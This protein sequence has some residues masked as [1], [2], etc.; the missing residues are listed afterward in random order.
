M[1]QFDPPLLTHA[2]KAVLDE[3]TVDT[4]APAV[5]MQIHRDGLSVDGVFGFSDPATQQAASS[6]QPFEVG[7]QGKMMTA[8]IVLQMVAEGKID[9]DASLSDYV[10]ASYMAGIANAGEATIR[11]LLANRSGVP[12]FDTVVGESGL[13]EF[14]ERLTAN[15]GQYMGPEVFLDIVKGEPATFA[16]GE[17]YLY[18]NTNF[19]LLGHLIET[20]SGNTLADEMQ[21]RIFDP[22]G[23]QSSK[24]DPFSRDDGR[25]NSYADL[26]DGMPIDVTQIPIDYAGAGGV[27]STTSDMIRFMDALLV[28]QTLLPADMLQQMTDFRGP[29][30]TP[31]GNGFGLGLSANL[32][33][34][35]LFIGFQGGTL[36]TNTGTILH[37]Q[38]GTIISVAATH[39][40]VD[41][42]DLLLNAFLQIF[43]DEAW[44]RF[45]PDA[46]SFLIAGA[47]AEIDLKEIAGIGETE[48]TKLFLN[49]A[50]LIFEGALSEQDVDRFSFED[51]SKLWIGSQTRDRFDVFRDA[52]ETRHL[53]N[54]LIGLGGKD[55]LAG[56]HGNDKLRGGADGD[57]L[58]GRTGDDVIDGGSGRDILRGGAGEDVL[59]G[60]TG[61]DILIGGRGSDVFV[62]QNG[63]GSDRI[64]GF[65]TG[66]DRLDFSQTGLQFD[67]LTIET[68]WWGGVRVIYGIGDFATITGCLDGLDEGDFI[69]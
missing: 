50:S 24:L 27:V 55:I 66:A 63:D 11:Q 53:D 29:D 2:P 3:F 43:E 12:D 36:G 56:G 45:D 19:L 7:S 18:S 69:F 58:S 35:E 9:L 64:I 25:L 61:R 14:I 33:N 40:N 23:M 51:G 8:V 67:D 68:L 49:D 38:S 34:G 26:G 46:D 65:H 60:G 44:A 42:S 6:D 21:T 62:F 57:W 39:S 47:A 52:P 1:S 17:G 16:P 54:Q 30:G 48:R 59:I 13:P 20:V 37:V 31:D 5:L 22:S 4:I 28:S 10:N 15:P 32:L 41:P